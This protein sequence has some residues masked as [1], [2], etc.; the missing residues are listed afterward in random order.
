MLEKVTKT[1]KKAA[2]ICFILNE[3]KATKT[4]KKVSK[5][6]LKKETK[7]Q[8][9]LATKIRKRWQKHGKGT[10]TLEKAQFGNPP[11]PNYAYAANTTACQKVFVKTLCHTMSG[12]ISVVV[13]S[14]L[15][16]K[17]QSQR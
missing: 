13:Q 8:K 2:K 4:L 15:N 3:K 11:P 7:T 17:G 10:K 16:Q 1:S 12:H 5:K 6:T 14:L 9:K